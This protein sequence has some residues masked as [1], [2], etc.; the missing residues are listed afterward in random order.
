MAVNGVDFVGSNGSVANGILWLSF[1]RINSNITGAYACIT[2]TPN[3]TSYTNFQVYFDD[4]NSIKNTR[5]GMMGDLNWIICN[6]QV[7]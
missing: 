6:P 1:I 2:S 7:P 5:H 4:G 3:G